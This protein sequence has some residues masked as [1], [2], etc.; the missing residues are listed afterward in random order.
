[1][2]AHTLI[3]TEK[4]DAAERIAKALD[5]RGKPKKKKEKGVPFFEA[6]RDK[7]LVVVSALGHLYTV[8]QER[9]KRNY[10]PVFNFR[11]V[12]RYRAERK[13]EQIRYWIEVISELAKDADEFIDSCD[14]DIEGSLIGYTILHYAC[15]GKDSVA[16]RMKFSTLTKKELEEAYEKPM[17]NL[18][19]PLIEAGRTRHEVDWLYG[20]NLSRALTLSAKRWSGRYTTLST[21]RVQGPTLSFLVER[22]KEIKS[23]VPTPYWEIK[24]KVEVAGDVFEVNYEKSPI[25]RKVEA[26]SIVSACEGK[27]GVVSSIGVREYQQKPPIPFD[28][29]AL[30]SEAYSLFRYTPRRT[31]DIAQRLYL[32][33]LISYPRTSSQKLPPVINYRN[34]LTSLGK[35]KPYSELTAL[36]LKKETLKPR[37]GKKEDPAHPAVYPTGNLPERELTD[38]EKRIWDLV[39]RRFMATFGEPA[40]KQSMKVIFE[41]EGHRFVLS[42]RRIVKEGWLRFYKPFLKGD[43]VILPPLKEGMPAYFKEVLCIDKYT[44]PPARFNPSSLL[45]KME[46]EGIGTKATRA[47]IIETLYRRGYIDGERIV[48]TDI[49]FDV[50]EVLERYCPLVVSVDMTRE[51][52][53]RMERIRSNGEKRE[54]VL[55][56]AVKRLKPIL[57][58]FKMKEELIGE[59][60]S[61]AIRRAR[62]NERII[63]ACPSCGDGRLMILY[64]RRTRKRFIGCTNYF[65][66]KCTTS[67]PLPQKG[68]VKPARKNCSKCGWP[69]VLVK[70][71][72]RRPW[73]LC[74]NPDCPSKEA[75]IKNEV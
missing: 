75:R 12:P 46:A 10:Y 64:S 63:G 16:K 33:A 65:K 49:G 55:L 14:Y 44:S 32:D 67:F 8:V 21:G 6:Y 28:L 27:E 30:Q 47:D 7:K 38:P 19:F 54:S 5:L 40:I 72:G 29:G 15:E 37:E 13:A 20:I 25:E 9:G 69:L 45:K 50:I 22:E 31:S 3:I 34:I 71:V 4:P 41:V 66:G 68:T 52:E 56:D 74:F 23:F 11:W 17:E 2:E 39:V 53:E 61:Q 24:A 57:E 18:D 35:H 51:L 59:A 73:N 26:D 36:L 58:S 1:M 70:T 42:G 43:E 62:L 48:V 60:L